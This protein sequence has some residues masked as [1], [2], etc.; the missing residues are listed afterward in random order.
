[1]KKLATVVMLLYA[2]VSAVFCQQVK[3]SCTAKLIDGNQA[4]LSFK[5]TMM[6]GWHIYSIQ[7][8]DGGPL[9]TSITIISSD[10]YV[11]VGKLVEPKPLTKWDG[12]F[13]M[14]VLYFEKEVVFQQK[15]KLS[16]K[17]VT[18]KGEIEYMTCDDHQCLPPATESFS[19]PI[20]LKQPNNQTSN[21]TSP[22]L[23][24]GIF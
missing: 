5:A 16:A 17:D 6:P 1:M 8:K 10:Q 24:A 9:K 2:G 14:Q 4:L 7:Q 21:L 12:G 11:L 3:W 23:R 20:Q 15:I 19:V 22:F 18:V 13:G